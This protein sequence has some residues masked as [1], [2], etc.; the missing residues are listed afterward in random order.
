[1]AKQTMVLKVRMRCEKCRTK[2]M[3][4]VAGTYGVTAVQ[5]EREQGKLMV[6]GERVDI[7]ALAQ[8]L[9]KKVGYTEIIYVAE[10]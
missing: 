6:E 4:I 2:A 10:V 9:T 8:T 7:A 1:M 3:T 5:L